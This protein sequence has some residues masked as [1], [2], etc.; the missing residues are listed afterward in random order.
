MRIFISGVLFNHLLIASRVLCPVALILVFCFLHLPLSSCTPK[1]TIQFHL[2]FQLLP[3]PYS[4]FFLNPLRLLNTIT[5]VFWR[6]LHFRFQFFQNL[7][8]CSIPFC[9]PFFPK[10]PL[11]RHSSTITPVSLHRQLGMGI[12]FFFIWNDQLT[13]VQTAA[14]PNSN[15]CVIGSG[16]YMAPD[17]C[18]T[19]LR[20]C[21]TLYPIP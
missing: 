5:F 15:F 14:L 12:C 17:I 8:L 20:P 18:H 16:Q 11:L 21:I 1:H 6:L 10:N 9:K 13:W 3:L 4:S 19:K 7:S 2:R